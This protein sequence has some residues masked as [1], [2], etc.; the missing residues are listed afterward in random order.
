MTFEQY[1]YYRM[2][3]LLWHGS[4]VYNGHLR[5]LVTLTTFADRLA[6]E[7]LLFVFTI[8]VR[9]VLDSNTHPSAC[10]A[11]PLTHYATAAMLMALNGLEEL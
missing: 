3:H 6:V 7:L 8:K 10:G 4:S 9:R 2:P 1:V 11:I 5:G